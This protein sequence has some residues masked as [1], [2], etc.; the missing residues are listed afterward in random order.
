[1]P[2]IAR[3]VGRCARVIVAAAQ[4]VVDRGLRSTHQFVYRDQLEQT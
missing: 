3:L 2:A 4:L 1:M